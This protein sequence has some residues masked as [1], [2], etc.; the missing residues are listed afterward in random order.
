M[1][2]QQRLVEARLAS[3]LSR[4]EVAYQIRRHLPESLWVSHETIRRLEVGHKEDDELDPVLI[5]GLAR[6]Y[7]VRVSD[8]SESIASSSKS[9]AELLVTS[10]YKSSKPLTCI[11]DF[12]WPLRFRD[13]RSVALLSI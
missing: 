6:V 4:T 3:G 10:M 2:I 11:W 13:D 9:L 7:G 5:A 8:L 1:T 12:L